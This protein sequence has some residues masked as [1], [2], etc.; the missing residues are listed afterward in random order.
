MTTSGRTRRHSSDS[1]LIDTPRSCGG[2]RSSGINRTQIYEWM[3]RNPVSTSSPE[4]SPASPSAPPASDRAHRMTAI[5]GRNLRE[6]WEPSGPV[7]AFLRTCL[8]SSVWRAALTGYSLIWIRS[9]TPAGRSLFR[10]RLSAP[11]TGATASGLWPM[12]RTA[13]TEHPGR[14]APPKPGQQAGLVE[15]VHG[16]QRLWMTPRHEGFDAGAHRGKPDSLHSAVKLLPTPSATD[17]KGSS[18]EGQRR[19]QLSEVVAGRKLSAAW[20]SRLMGYPDSWMD[21]IPTDPLAPIG[22]TVSP[23]S[24]PTSTTA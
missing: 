13:E 18:Q 8:E 5:S 9:A 4:D 21:D 16:A 11:T 2:L 22:R 6:L 19:G 15:A 1:P 14:T 23:A 3:E 10:L 20:V 7:G 17:Y 24:P 12:P